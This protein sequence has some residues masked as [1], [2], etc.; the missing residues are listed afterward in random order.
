MIQP[1]QAPA[2]E[3]EK[4]VSE[5]MSPAAQTVPEVYIPDL[6]NIN[7][8]LNLEYPR[9]RLGGIFWREKDFNSTVYLSFDDGP[10][11][12]LMKGNEGF[13]TISDSILDTLKVHNIKA[14]FFIN[15][16]N[17]EFAVPAERDE[18]KRVLM[19][20]INEGH[21]IGNH[22]YNHHNLA[23]GI[24]A[25]G[26]NDREDIAR[27]FNMT[28][29]GLNDILEFVYPLVLVRPPYAEPGR[30]NELDL[31][32]QSEQQY[33]ISLQ[34]D[35]YDYAFKADG[36]WNEV[37]LLER[38]EELLDE[39]PEG[40]VLLLHELESTA[41]ILPGYIDKIITEKGFTTG[42]MEDLLIKKYGR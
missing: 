17:L 26:M 42:K 6:R 29:A 23:R 13:Q 39:Q 31:W 2:A 8:I 15:G 9:D 28:Q 41:A 5:N 16:Q 38:M 35:S 12:N 10:N 22:S 4:A 18:L 14:V 21:L 7:S 36:N 33:L 3:A 20:M 19:R 11:M 27:E 1:E 34:F 30:S 25:D 24:Y 40:G 37:R 32:L